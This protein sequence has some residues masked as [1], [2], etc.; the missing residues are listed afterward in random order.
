MAQVCRVERH[1]TSTKTGKTRTE[2]VFCITDLSPEQASPEQLLA[3]NRGHWSIENRLHWVRDVTFDEDR[4]Q[5]RKGHGPQVLAC[6]R[7]AV[8]GLLRCLRRSARQSLASMIR[9][10]AANPAQALAVFLS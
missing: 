1:V 3:L 4:C 7:N 9:H 8:I 10:F 2:Q 6:L 5:V